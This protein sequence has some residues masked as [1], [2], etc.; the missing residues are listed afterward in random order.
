MAST[1]ILKNGTGS[2]IPSA[3]AHGEPAINVDTGLFYYG[4]GSVGAV[5]TFSNFTN[6]TA[7]ISSSLGGNISAS[8]DVF[9]SNVHLPGQ[10]RVTFQED[11]Y[12]TG[13]N[14][15]LTLDGDE[16]VSFKADDHVTFRD[17]S[18]DDY[19]WIDANNG[20]ITASGNI[21]ASGNIEANY[22]NAKSGTSNASY[23]FNGLKIVYYDNAYVFGR[24]AATKISGS[25]IE[26][27]GGHVTASGNISASGDITAP[28]YVNQIIPV[29]QNSSYY[30][31][32]TA[33]SLL[34]G[35]GT[36]GFADRVWNQ[37]YTPADMVSDFNSNAHA[38]CGVFVH[39]KLKNIK[40]IGSI[41]PSAGGTTTVSFWLFKLPSHITTAGAGSAPQPVFIASGS[42]GDTTGASFH[43]VYI[44]GSAAGGHGGFNPSVSVEA[45]DLII[46]AAQTTEGSGNVK[47]N[48]SVTGELDE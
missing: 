40:L 43:T 25:T 39:H 35:H 10:G 21:S 12:I 8:G 19:L 22:F 38:N 7:S 14:N 32:P 11:Q 6:I 31:G 36:Y 28:K 30:N 15:R 17:N 34:I 24:E 37:Q 3:L 33:N 48:Y 13:Q 47:I 45:G 2:A 1:I 23:K 46:V 29:I 26:L 27:S 44:T 4:S 20:H 5:K 41:K 9:A 42:S 18:G 16:F